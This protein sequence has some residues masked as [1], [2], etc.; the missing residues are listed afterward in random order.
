MFVRILLARLYTSLPQEERQYDQRHKED[1]RQRANP[2]EITFDVSVIRIEF[3]AA[4]R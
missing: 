4:R 3:S 1:P 2:S